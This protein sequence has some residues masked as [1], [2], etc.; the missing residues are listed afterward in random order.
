MG[1]AFLNHSGAEP[2]FSGASSTK[3]AS[4]SGEMSLID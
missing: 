3:S 1:N 2:I 4:P